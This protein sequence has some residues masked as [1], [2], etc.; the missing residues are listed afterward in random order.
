[1]QLPLNVLRKA[2]SLLL[3]LSVSSCKV[4]A[5]DLPG[6]KG[7]MEKFLNDA[8]EVLEVISD[9]YRAFILCLENSSRLLGTGG[10]IGKNEKKL[11]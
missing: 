8:L 3:R 11:H 7:A 9:K 4:E 6:R 1:M 2:S 10:G 5:R